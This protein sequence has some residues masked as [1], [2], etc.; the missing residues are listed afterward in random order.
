M[1]MLT[2]VRADPVELRRELHDLQQLRGRIVESL[3]REHSA[4]TIRG[5]V[6]V[7]GSA[8]GGRG[9]S[10]PAPNID[11]GDLTAGPFLFRFQ[12]RA[13]QQLARSNCL[14]RSAINIGTSNQKSHCFAS[15]PKTDKEEL[16]IDPVLRAFTVQL[17][18]RTFAPS[19][20][21]PTW[22]IMAG[23]AAVLWACLTILGLLPIEWVIFRNFAAM[24]VPMEAV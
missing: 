1:L 15:G 14:S 3:H 7:L 4:D 8:R 5:S 18:A 10:L 11:L 12:E 19:Y 6:T 20:A 13:R 21:T 23:I 2:V 16:E 24:C 22:F 17:E 9:D